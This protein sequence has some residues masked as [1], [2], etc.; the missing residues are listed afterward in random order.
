MSGLVRRVGASAA[1]LAD[2]LASA[3]ATNA[4]SGRVYLSSKL[5]Q[6]PPLLEEDLKT[7]STFKKPVGQ[8][9]VGQV[10]S[11]VKLA[12]GAAAG[13]FIGEMIARGLYPMALVFF[14]VGGV[15]FD[16]RKH[17]WLSCG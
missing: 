1:K 11:L 2:K 4:S 5:R 9:T 3:E 6:L 12:A 13:F 14:C 10:N 15:L 17:L 16:S 7:I 8:Y